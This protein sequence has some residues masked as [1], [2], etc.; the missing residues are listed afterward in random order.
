MKKA[1]NWAVTGA[2]VL[3][4][5]VA[6]VGYA[7]LGECWR[8]RQLQARQRVHG[9]CRTAYCG[10]SCWQQTAGWVDGRSTAITSPVPAALPLRKEWRSMSSHEI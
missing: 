9:L 10:R 3:Y 6:C 7:A 5:S 1:I 2:F 8:G 4:L